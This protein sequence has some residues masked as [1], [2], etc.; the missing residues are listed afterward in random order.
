M[1][2]NHDSMDGEALALTWFYCCQHE[3]FL[4]N[5]KAITAIKEPSQN[6]KWAFMTLKAHLEMSEFSKAEKTITSLMEEDCP[7]VRDKAEA[8]RWHGELL[9]RQGT[10][11]DAMEFYQ[12]CLA[13]WGEV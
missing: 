7:T 5:S 8:Y 4:K 6:P 13:A 3:E 11:T 10:C 2:S 9:R 12:R 1:E